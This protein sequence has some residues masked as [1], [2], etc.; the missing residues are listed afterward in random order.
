MHSSISLPLI[1]SS[2]RRFVGGFPSRALSAIVMVAAFTLLSLLAVSQAQAQDQVQN[3]D[4][5]FTLN[6]KN[7][8]ISSLIQTVSR[9][10]GKEL[11][12]GSASEG[13]RHGDLG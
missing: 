12:G 7:A 1:T 8:D 6:L 2:Q 5:S 11:R 10:T 9:Q 13:A 3:Q 4:G